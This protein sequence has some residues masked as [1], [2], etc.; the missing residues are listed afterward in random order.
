[1]G[2]S[3]GGEEVAA[4]RL[5]LFSVIV[6]V[7]IAAY[8]ISRP[9]WWLVRVVPDD[10]FYYLKIAS[11]MARERLSS[12][13]GINPTNGYHP[14]WM[15]LVV[16]LAKLFDDKVTLLRAVLATALLLHL[17]TGYCLSR[18]L[19][20]W[21]SPE[22]SWIGGAC[23]ILNP[24]PVFL[25]IEGMEASLYVFALSIA[26]WLYAAHVE[27][28]LEA[29]SISR[30]TLVSMGLVFGACILAR[31]DQIVLCAVVSVAI[32]WRLP[33]RERLRFIAVT[34]G[35]TV[36]CLVP[37]VA[38][39]RLAT[40]TWFQH[41]GAM[42]FMWARKE[43]VGGIEGALEYLTREWL[44]YPLVDYK[45]LDRLGHRWPAVRVISTVLITLGL[46][47]ALRRGLDRSDTRGLARASLVLVAGTLLTGAI[48]GLFFTDRQDWYR[49]QPALILYVVLYG[50]IVR[51]VLERPDR[52]RIPPIAVGGASV[53]VFAATLVGLV[54][55]AKT[56]P[57]QRDVY[58]SQPM[59]EQLVPRGQAIGCF[60]AGIPAYFSDRTVI[61]LDGLTNNAV[62][63]YYQR[64]EFDQYLRDARIG[65][66]ADEDLSMKR[67][68]LFVDKPVPM[69]E[70]ATASMTWMTAKRRLWHLAPR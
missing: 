27:G 67:A 41:S 65:Y 56:Y 14:G 37:W 15:F 7:S 2:P 64:D 53:A 34:G 57:W 25:A 8:A 69:E 48:Y 49:G 39:S 45:I 51:G 55:T 1:M 5:F 11:I 10:T 33:A 19:R 40:G 52:W 23:W 20:R 17:G 46:L 12:F 16:I 36:L 29:R 50:A 9:I 47:A 35:I 13:D 22:W 68:M 26:L 70:L 24:L 58:E 3:N 63:P 62:F 28:G 61:N 43:H 54:L 60:N 6:T 18:T 21:M 59:F 38:Y 4:K 44:T 31:T 30:R 66:I 42:K 32:M